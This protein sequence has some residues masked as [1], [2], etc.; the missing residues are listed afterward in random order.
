MCRT[1]RATLPM[2]VTC[3]EV[4]PWL[5][6]SPNPEGVGPVHAASEA[7]CCNLIALMH[8]CNAKEQIGTLPPERLAAT[9]CD[10]TWCTQR[11]LWCTAA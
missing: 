11:S 7:S 9:M 5:T 8:R 6:G 2:L 10:S 3:R 4:F 1:L